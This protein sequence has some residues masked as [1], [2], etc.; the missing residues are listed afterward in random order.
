V[1]FTVA[2]RTHPHPMFDFSVFRIRDFSGAILGCVGM[3]C[4]YWPFMIYLP[5]Y[6]T[7]GLGRDVA[8]AGF[9]LLAYTVPFLVMPPV[10]QW[11]LLR[12]DA[13]VVIPGGLFVIGLGFL[14]MKL[15]SDASGH[16]PWPV[17]PGALLAGIG[18]GL[19]TTPASSM[20][21]SAVPAERAGMASGMD[22]SARLITLALNIAVMGLVLVAGLE[23]SLQASQG[24]SADAGPLRTVAEQLASGN[25]AGALQAVP[26][27]AGQS[28]DTHM[29][30]GALTQGFGWVMLYG[31]MAAWITAALSWVVFRGLHEAV[32]PQSP[33]GTKSTS[34]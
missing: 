23:A 19:T 4:S 12:Y 29:L 18:L 11:L 16:G 30:Q 1:G 24:A 13:R 6:F 25:L 33:A 5:L 9:A 2:E 22:V 14:L 15:G 32:I 10:A 8:A 20:T 7:A 28:V 3:N 21:K 31:G 34:R 26:A 27:S 17:L